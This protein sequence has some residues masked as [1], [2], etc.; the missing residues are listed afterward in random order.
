MAP[1]MAEN[2]G[3]TLQVYHIESLLVTELTVAIKVE[4]EE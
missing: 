3:V 1:S 4:S 2:N